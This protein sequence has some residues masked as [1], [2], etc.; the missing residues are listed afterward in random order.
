MIF[1]LILLCVILMTSIMKRRPLRHSLFNFMARLLV[2]RVWRSHS[3]LKKWCT[4]G[5]AIPI[6]PSCP[7]ILSIS[8]A[9]GVPCFSTEARIPVHAANSL[10][11]SE[12]RRRRMLISQLSTVFSSS[13]AASA[14]SLLRAL[15]FSRGIGSRMCFDVGLRRWPGA[16]L[17]HIWSHC[18]FL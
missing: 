6:C 13:R 1:R 5:T 10:S 11:G 7:M 17:A 15:K 4:N 18:L 2:S 9:V 12:G 16:W 3:R 8:F 14:L